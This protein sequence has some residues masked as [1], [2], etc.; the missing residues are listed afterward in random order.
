MPLDRTSE[1]KL[2]KFRNAPPMKTPLAWHNL[3]HKKMRAAT[4]LAGVCIT[5]VLIYMQLGFYDSCERSATMISDLL[6]FDVVLVST[7]YFNT[8]FAGTIRRQRLSQVRAVPGVDRAL[9]VYFG[10][11]NW[12]NGQTGTQHEMLLI[13]V[14]PR[15]ETFRVPSLVGKSAALRRTDTAIVDTK[16]LKQYGSLTPGIVAQIDNRRIDIVDVYTHGGGFTSNAQAVV[17]D[18][19][20]A[21]I[22]H[23]YPVQDV[24]LGLVK[25]QPGCD[26]GTAIPR[27]A[28]ALPNDV[29]VWTRAELNQQSITYAMRIKPLGLM[30]SSGVVLALIIGAVILYQILASEIMSHLKQFATLKAI[31]YGNAFLNG[32]VLKEAL[33]FAVAAFFP[34]TAISYGLYTLTRLRTKLPMVMTPGRVVLVLV[35]SIF[36]CSASGLLASRKVRRADP[37]DLF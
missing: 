26:P 36:M 37:V 22:L 8:K 23:G 10:V 16:A 31:G 6:D 13:G 25:L 11:G 19:T 20:F 21:R 14:D 4:S 32:V 27:I 7:Q 28:A 29:R 3:I 9:P 15:Q 18:Q 35:L 12:R 34:A 1:Q 2:G 17:S 33:I 5:M 24:S 30:F